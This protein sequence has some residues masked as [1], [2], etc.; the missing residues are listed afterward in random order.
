MSAAIGAYQVEWTE[1]AEVARICWQDSEI[2]HDNGCIRAGQR[3]CSLRNW[4]DR[5]RPM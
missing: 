4:L 1:I 2:L 3:Y 5:Y